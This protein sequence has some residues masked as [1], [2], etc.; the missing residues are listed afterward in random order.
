MKYLPI[1]YNLQDLYRKNTIVIDKQMQHWM[2]DKLYFLDVG[3]VYHY[4]SIP[5]NPL[6]RDSNYWIKRTYEELY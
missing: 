5:P 3:W 6:N 2:D 1:R 4:N